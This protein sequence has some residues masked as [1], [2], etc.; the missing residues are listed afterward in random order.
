MQLLLLLTTLQALLSEPF[1]HRH[2]GCSRVCYGIASGGCDDNHDLQALVFI[3]GGA[4][5]IRSRTVV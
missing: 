1:P 5:G 2:E 3:S 4:I